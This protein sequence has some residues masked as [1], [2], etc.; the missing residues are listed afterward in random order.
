MKILAYFIWF[1]T[2]QL[3]TIQMDQ[4]KVVKVLRSILLSC[5]SGMFIHDLVKEYRVEEATKIPFKTFGFDSFVDFLRTTGGFV[6]TETKDGLMVSAEQTANS[7]HVN[8]SVKGQNCSKKVRRKKRSKLQH[9]RT[10]LDI[11]Y[12][13]DHTMRYGIQLIRKQIQPRGHRRARVQCGPSS[14]Q[15]LQNNLIGSQHNSNRRVIGSARVQCGPLAQLRNSIGYQN[16]GSNNRNGQLV[17][18]NETQNKQSLGTPTKPANSKLLKFSQ[19]L[20][21]AMETQ[22]DELMPKP[23]PKVCIRPNLNT[24]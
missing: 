22:P 10:P 7:E 3:D 2:A 18:V 14:A 20:I 23:K 4:E 16:N 21:R 13:D 6:V 12:E 11:I 15:I 24:R 5:K 8:D 9:P 1:I 17:T 19:A